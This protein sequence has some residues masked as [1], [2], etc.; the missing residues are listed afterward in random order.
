MLI[1]VQKSCFL[2]P[3]SLK[4]HNRT[5]ITQAA[6]RKYFKY[7]T[8]TD[9]QLNSFFLYFQSKHFECLCTR[10]K[11]PTELGSHGS[12][13]RCGECQKGFL[14]PSKWE[15]NKCGFEIPDEIGKSV[16]FKA[17]K[18]VAYLFVFSPR[19]PSKREKNI[20]VLLSLY[21]F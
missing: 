19:V 7:S 9:V 13:I 21:I 6:L 18:G 20:L 12:S 8:D 2:E 1:L 10:C 3:Q 16:L 17:Y 11:D 5:D 14:T 15:C 4:F